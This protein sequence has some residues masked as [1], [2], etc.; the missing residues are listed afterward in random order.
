LDDD[1][2]LRRFVRA[3]P[4]VVADVAVSHGLSAGTSAMAV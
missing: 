3:A 4:T 1:D 2:D